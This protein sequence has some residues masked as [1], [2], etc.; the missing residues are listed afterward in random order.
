M[1][2]TLFSLFVFVLCGGCVRFHVV[3]WCGGCV[4]FLFSEFYMYLGCVELRPL[5]HEISYA[6]RAYMCAISAKI[7]G[8]IRAYRNKYSAIVA[9]MR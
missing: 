6:I 9:K 2:D 8:A 1:R 3:F 4:R 5:Y 7:Q